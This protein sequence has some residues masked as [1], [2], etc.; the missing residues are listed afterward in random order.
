MANGGFSSARLDRMNRVMAGYVERGEIPGIV[1]LLSRRG[2]THVHA[3]G[4]M[5]A[6]GGE[7]MRPDTIFRIAS[8]SKPVAAV[9][10]MILVEEC[11]L[12]LD[13]PVDRFLPELADRRVL[14]R[15][16]GPVDDT[17][18]ARRP[19]TARDLLTLRMGFGYILDPAAAGYPIHEAMEERGLAVGPNPTSL[20]PDEWMRRLGELPLMHHPGEVWMYDTALDVLG[21]LVAR[22]AG[23]PLED[24]LRE[25]VFEPLGMK[26]TGFHVPPEKIERL[27]PFYRSDYE[28]GGLAL[29]DPAAGGLWSRPPAFPSARGGL[30]STA[31]DFHA[32]GEMLLNGGRLGGERILSRPSVQA[33][34]TNQL[35]PGQADASAMILGENRGWGLGMSVVTRRDGVAASPGRFGWDG[36][37]GTSWSSDPAEG[38][39]GILLTQRLWDSPGGPGVYHD[40]W[41]CAY[42]AI[43]D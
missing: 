11:R 3:H 13:E 9:G 26:D 7:P 20:A 32:F 29:Y 30:V 6:G 21:V 18:P 35:Q 4:T 28:N 1:T 2:E 25:R 16:D 27:P 8:L 34:T 39:S 41:T 36:G 40:F 22:A 17:E 5:A 12:R 31:H 24:F 15:L 33:M 38:L 37:Y 19:L 43:D 42:Q 14:K 23:Q 10:A